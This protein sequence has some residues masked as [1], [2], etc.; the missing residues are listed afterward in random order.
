MS[1][2]LRDKQGE[3]VYEWEQE[4]SPEE[5]RTVLEAY[6]QQ[7]RKAGPPAPPPQEQAAA[8]PPPQELTPP[9]DMAELPLGGLAPS[10]SGG[11]PNFQPPI[12][13]AAQR[14]GEVLTSP[15]TWGAEAGGALVGAG[16]AL[17]ME[18]EGSELRSPQE[19]AAQSQVRPRGEAPPPET[20]MQP[21]PYKSLYEGE[22]GR[23]ESEEAQV[24]AAE[25]AKTEEGLK[26][27]ATTVGKAAILEGKSPKEAQAAAENAVEKQLA[28]LRQQMASKNHMLYAPM[29]ERLGVQIDQMTNPRNATKIAALMAFTYLSAGAAAPY[30]GPALAAGLGVGVGSAAVDLAE[31]GLDPEID[32]DLKEIAKNA[33]LEG[34]TVGFTSKIPIRGGPLGDVLRKFTPGAVGQAIAGGGRE[35]IQEVLEESLQALLQGE[36]PKAENLLLAAA[37]GGIYGPMFERVLI[38]LG[39][40]PDTAA[41]A[42]RLQELG[43]KQYDIPIG[44]Q[45]PLGPESFPLEPPPGYTGPERQLEAGPSEL[46][47]AL[48]EGAG[49]APPGARDPRAEALARRGLPS[50]LEPHRLLD[51]D[52]VSPEGVSGEAGVPTMRVLPDGTV[53]HELPAE[54]AGASSYPATDPRVPEVLAGPVR[55]VLGP[56]VQPPP[57]SEP[58]GPLKPPPDPLA[59]S[60]DEGLAQGRLFPGVRPVP[61]QGAD[62]A[63]RRPLGQPTGELSFPEPPPPPPDPKVTRQKAIDR[64]VSEGLA[65]VDQQMGELGNLHTA[66]EASKLRKKGIDLPNLLDEL[67]EGNPIDPDGEYYVNQNELR[68]LKKDLRTQAEEDYDRRGKE[69]G[70]LEEGPLEP[71]PGEDLGDLPP[72]LSAAIDAAAAEEGDLDDQGLVDQLTVQDTTPWGDPLTPPP[73]DEALDEAPDSP[74]GTL[75]QSTL[76]QR[77]RA[78]LPFLRSPS[79]KNPEVRVDDADFAGRERTPELEEAVDVVRLDAQIRSQAGKGG[80]KGWSKGGRPKSW[81]KWMIARLAV[82][83]TL[84][85]LDPE[86]RTAAVSIV[87]RARRRAALGARLGDT[88]RHGTLGPRLKLLSLSPDGRNAKVLRHG[89]EEEVPTEGLSG[90]PHFKPYTSIAENLGLTLV[91]EMDRAGA[92]IEGIIGDPTRE[93]ALDP[94]AVATAQASQGLVSP[95]AKT[96]I[97]QQVESFLK[98]PHVLERLRLLL[99]DAPQLAEDITVWDQAIGNPGE[100][101]VGKFTEDGRMLLDLGEIMRAAKGDP[102]RFG[103]TLTKVIQH[104]ITHAIGQH[105][106]PG[107]NIEGETFLPGEQGVSPNVT[108]PEGAVGPG[109]APMRLRAQ[110][111]GDESRFMT[112]WDAVRNDPELRG[113]WERLSTL[114]EGEVQ[115]SRRSEEGA[116]SVKML[117]WMGAGAGAL[118]VAAPY[119]LANPGMAAGAAFLGY[120]GLS[121]VGSKVPAAADALTRASAAGRFTVALGNALNANLRLAGAATVYTLPAV[122]YGI[123]RASGIR[124]SIQGGFLEESAAKLAP[125]WKGALNLPGNLH[126]TLIGTLLA[127]KRNAVEWEALGKL[128]PW[129]KNFTDD[130]VK[131]GAANDDAL[132]QIITAS[133]VDKDFVDRF[134]HFT[135]GTVDLDPEKAAKIGKIPTHLASAFLIF[136]AAVDRT[137]R[138]LYMQMALA[139]IMRKHHVRN[140]AEL[141]EKVV[142]PRTGDFRV[143]P[144]GQEAADISGALDTA[145]QGAFNYSGALRAPRQGP[146]KFLGKAIEAINA[147]PLPLAHLAAPDVALFSNFTLANVPE[148]ALQHIPLINMLAPRYQE[149]MRSGRVRDSAFEARRAV[150][151]VEGALAEIKE[152]RISELDR[153][154]LAITELQRQRKALATDRDRLP[155]PHRGPLKAAIL[156]VDEE[157][158]EQRLELKRTNDRFR[159]RLQAAQREVALAKQAAR[160]MVSEYNSLR[161]SGYYSK[162][163]IFGEFAG[164]GLWLMALAASLRLAREDDGT[165]PIEI[166]LGEVD[167]NGIRKTTDISR[168]LGPLTPAWV[169]GDY[170]GRKLL[171]ERDPEKYANVTGFYAPHDHWKYMLKGIGYRQDTKGGGGLGA[172]GAF[173]SG[174]QEQFTRMVD[175]TVADLTRL[176]AGQGGW[177]RDIVKGGQHAAFGAPENYPAGSQHEEAWRP[178]AEG[179][180]GMNYLGQVMDRAGETMLNTMEAEVLQGAASVPESFDKLAGKKRAINRTPLGWV[181]TVREQSSL[182]R[183]F[184]N[185]RGEQL[186]QVLPASTG[187]QWYDDIVGKTVAESYR[188]EGIFE[189]VE[190]ETLSPEARWQQLTDRMREINMKAHT[191]AKRYADENELQVPK[192][193]GMLEK[194]RMNELRQEDPKYWEKQTLKDI[195]YM[196]TEM[197]MDPMERQL[198]EEGQR[199]LYD[200]GGEEG[201]LKPPPE[202]GGL[203]VY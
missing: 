143:D 90:G 111:S 84:S 97:L 175:R 113:E 71:P 33:L 117:G 35:S 16:Q 26:S 150:R 163:Q 109:E 141:L 56:G 42:A 70:S 156:E 36:V 191:A 72:E 131:A 180:S 139:P 196:N 91:E 39:V 21:S 87:D 116:V 85:S 49:H 200:E 124:E 79:E 106:L 115:N 7:R 45:E 151:S 172:V 186:G 58:P 158:T 32:V 22:Q 188:E 201:P 46:P 176:Y 133:G 157:I 99:A 55:E 174:S 142:D 140:F 67:A 73:L 138:M 184:E 190:D 53:V 105:Q 162:G 121:M 127:A 64:Q 107:E 194:A 149:S 1:Y 81:T 187:V 28:N 152:A 134:F 6:G 95:Q 15:E 146:W 51:E 63:P 92:T 52:L 40:D 5:L 164:S 119:M 108:I 29:S 178:M 161:K 160:P 110:Y 27:L 96:R 153:G 98:Q 44:P 165:N 54:G 182:N 181:M 198:Y 129:S 103:R 77:L 173:F 43:A 126:E 13:Q 17:G 192:L 89:V 185:I 166:P 48:G 83:R 137:T 88:V 123:G 102:G 104:E 114:A 24:Q 20:P 18:V 189:L 66:T 136:N 120:L 159:T 199:T 34:V 61:R 57:A 68:S 60:F 37:G 118:L 183:F 14:A 11:G 169:I 74:P 2:K 69:G 132:K 31:A 25:L 50:G 78:A 86:T 167:E 101:K 144:L 38:S 170:I 65:L 41:E 125:A 19:I 171:V 193:Q 168:P 94:D 122:A 128:S 47:I 100:K 93:M 145:V 130:L 203:G 9:P 3:V 59:G 23:I 75:P 155:V 202:D 62:R 195:P 80:P 82:S 76:S 30:T 147:M 12:I 112:G 8:P 135:E 154:G 10:G 148:I 197:Q 4:P 177:M 179:E